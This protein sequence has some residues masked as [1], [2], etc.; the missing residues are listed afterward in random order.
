MGRLFAGTIFVSIVAGYRAEER[1]TEPIGRIRRIGYR[2]LQ[3]TDFVPGVGLGSWMYHAQRNF[4]NHPV[5]YTAEGLLLL[6]YNS[7]L[8]IVADQAYKLIF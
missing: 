2:H 7:G 4:R 1:R 8:G 5:R 6:S 3:G